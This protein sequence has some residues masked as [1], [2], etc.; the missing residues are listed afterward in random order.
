MILFL[1]LTKLITEK[2]MTHS[3][4]NPIFSRIHLYVLVCASMCLSMSHRYNRTITMNSIK[5]FKFISPQILP[6]EWWRCR[7]MFINSSFCLNTKSFNQ[8]K[9]SLVFANF[10]LI[11]LKYAKSVT[12]RQKYKHTLLTHP[13]THKQ[14]YI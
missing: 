7:I 5:Y 1:Y 13:H 12:H 4:A 10:L 6:H 3:K 14:Y 11:S 2:T 8:I 9:V